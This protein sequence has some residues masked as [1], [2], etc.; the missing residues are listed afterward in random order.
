ME[1][2]N[3][4]ADVIDRLARIETKQKL[5]QDEVTDIRGLESRIAKLEGELN[6]RKGRA[7]LFN[8]LLI[9]IG[10]GIGSVIAV[11]VS[12]LLS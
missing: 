3:F 4:E 1:S 8:S 12:R 6:Q 5:I 9:M 10:A 11:L 2:N 7:A